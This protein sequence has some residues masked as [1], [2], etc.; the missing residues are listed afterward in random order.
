MPKARAALSRYGHQ[1]VIGNDLHRRKFEVVFVEPTNAGRSTITQEPAVST[2]SGPQTPPLEASKKLGDDE[3]KET[4]LK[5][6]EASERSTGQDELE[7]ESLIVERLV[8][9]HTAWLEA[10]RKA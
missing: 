10:G 6:D 1:I 5:L 2:E 3:F 7:I 8:Q 9:R 4:W